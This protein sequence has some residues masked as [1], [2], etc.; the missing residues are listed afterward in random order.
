MTQQIAT[1][2]DRTQFQDIF[3]KVFANNDIYFRTKSGDLKIK[4]YGYTEGLAAFRIPYL[5]NVREDNLIFTRSGSNIIYAHLKF[6][7]KQ[8]EEVYIFYP[9][10]I[11]I[12][13]ED[14]RENRTA[15]A[16]GGGKSIL[17]VTNIISDF[18][19]E[20]SIAL[21]LKKSE[22]IKEI[23]R[24]DMEKQF[25]HIKIYFCN[26]GTSDP[27]MKY[28]TEQK[29]PIFISNISKPPPESEQRRYNDYINNIYS[30]DY[31]LL[32]RKNFVSEVS[33][34]ILFRTK[35]PYGYIQVNNTNPLTE[36]TLTLVKRIAIIAEEL[37]HKQGIFPISQEK[38]LVS[39][40]SKNGLGIVFK[41]RKFIRY[42]KEKC[43]VYF[44]MIFPGNKKASILATVR[45]ISL[46]EN[47]IIK[48]GC[49][50]KE[51]DALS[52][53]IYEEYIESLPRAPEPQPEPKE[54]EPRPEPDGADE[55]PGEGSGEGKNDEGPDLI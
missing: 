31:F 3:Y 39:D 6:A 49:E 48:I 24:Y 11:Q 23:L 16:T 26:E 40:I 33:V 10:K 29:S 42:F 1:I 28:F 9:E 19:I 36:P 4:F 53:V 5:K 37:F 34:P 47:K 51:M 18:I 30:K 8:E 32:N 45:N 7:E 13:S 21:D 41:E 43:L 38:L 15:L 44:D 54:Q 17:Y 12:I 52:E 20:N 50:I 46:L 22:K 14:R 35:I 27:R 2:T 25:Q 55:Q